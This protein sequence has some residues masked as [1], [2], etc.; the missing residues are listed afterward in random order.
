MRNEK[1]KFEK[2]EIQNGKWKLWNIE[3]L[4]NGTFLNFGNWIFEKWQ[5]Q[6]FQYVGKKWMFEKWKK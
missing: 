3:H 4:K 5:N 6:N 2:W 1:M